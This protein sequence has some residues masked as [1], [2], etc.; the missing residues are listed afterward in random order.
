MGWLVTWLTLTPGFKIKVGVS[1]EHPD[2]ESVK[3]TADP[4]T[5]AVAAQGLMT[6]EITPELLDQEMGLKCEPMATLTVLAK[7]SM[8]DSRPL[9][10]TKD[11]LRRHIYECTAVLKSMDSFA[12]K[13]D[14][15]MIQYRKKMREKEN[16]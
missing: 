14:E 16:E 1:F 6:H 12:G 10:M 5:L 7:H 8:A 2:D 4:E 15:H 3:M 13:V 9:F 11:E